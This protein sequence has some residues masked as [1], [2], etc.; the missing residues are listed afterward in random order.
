MKNKGKACGAELRALMK[1]HHLTQAEVAKFSGFAVKTVEGW[2]ADP[3]AASSRN[4]S[5]R[6]L[7]IIRGLL[8][9]F[10]EQRLISE[11]TNEDG[12][13]NLHGAIARWLS[14]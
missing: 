11:A 9:A 7:A 14:Q 5:Q 2:L 8:P 12:K 4:F 10:L 1:E 13:I 3:S 6:N